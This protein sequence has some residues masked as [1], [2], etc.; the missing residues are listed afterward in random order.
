M[1]YD[2]LLQTVINRRNKLA[3]IPPPQNNT[4]LESQSSTPLGLEVLG[5][6]PGSRSD[7]TDTE[8]SQQAASGPVDRAGMESG[9][10][11]TSSPPNVS[12]GGTEG[13]ESPG[14]FP[15]SLT[16]HSKYRVPPQQSRVGAGLGNLGRYLVDECHWTREEFLEVYHEAQSLASK[17][18]DFNYCISRQ[19]EHTVIEVCKSVVSKHPVARGYDEHWPIWTMIQLHLKKTSEKY[20]SKERNRMTHGARG[21][22]REFV[23]EL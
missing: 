16:S 6:V 13:K 12:T 21:T 3:T 20:R 15:K 5:D 23:G 22:R 1:D 11:A 14:I 19:N 17:N 18:L 9:V 4:P 2:D 8:S 7:Q 10:Q